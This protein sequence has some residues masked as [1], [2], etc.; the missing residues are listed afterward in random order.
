[1]YSGSRPQG[2]WIGYLGKLIGLDILVTW[3]LLFVFW[4]FV[5]R[6]PALFYLLHLSVIGMDLLVCLNVYCKA[7]EFLIIDFGFM[8][9]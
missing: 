5:P 8:A 7:T 4:I 3:I 6:H 9:V 1:M 2:N